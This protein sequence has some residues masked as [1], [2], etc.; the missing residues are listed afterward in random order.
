[1]PGMGWKRDLPDPRDYRF[2]SSIKAALL[3][4]G[5]DRRSAMPP[6]ALEQGVLGS[7]VSNACSVAY[8]YELMREGRQPI[9]PS[10]LFQYYNQRVIENTVQSD[11]GSSIRAA[12]QTL[13]HDGVCPESLWP[14]DIVQFRTRPSQQC[15]DVA[16]K[17]QVVQYYRVDQTPQEIMGALAE[18]YLVVFGFMLYKQFEQVGSQGTVTMPPTNQ[19]PL[20]GHAGLLC[21]YSSEGAWYINRNSWGVGWG[22][23]GYC[24][25]PSSYVMHP[26]LADDFWALKLIEPEDAPPPPTPWVGDGILTKMAEYGDSPA[27]GEW[28]VDPAGT[29]R[30]A[31]G[32]KGI[33]YTYI[34][35]LGVVFAFVPKS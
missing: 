1:M 2:R 29:Y 31:Y 35:K 12:F 15:Y 24:Y 16:L 11:A 5:V 20:G 19:A 33:Q 23:E 26:Q 25:F 6:G 3:P 9:N 30:I 28:F 21:G 22:D 13:D 7:C 14:Y 32:I 27:D 34:A 10:R 17:G 18:G 8:D 4:A